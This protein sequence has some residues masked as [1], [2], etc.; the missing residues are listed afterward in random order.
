MKTITQSQSDV[1]AS[2]PH[3]AQVP[4]TTMNF[5][6]T[7]RR[8]G[9]LPPTAASSSDDEGVKNEERLDVDVSV[10]TGTESQEFFHLPSQSQQQQSGGSGE[11]KL[12]DGEMKKAP[13]RDTDRGSVV[14]NPLLFV[15]DRTPSPNISDT[16][17][18]AAAN[19]TSDFNNDTKTSIVTSSHTSTASSAGYSADSPT[20]AVSALP[21]AA[22]ITTTMHRDS[23][24]ETLDEDKL[25]QS[26]QQQDQQQQ[27][28]GQQRRPSSSAT[29]SS[30]VDNTVDS[31]RQCD[32]T[33]SQPPSTSPAA[34]ATAGPLQPI[35]AAGISRAD[36]AGDDVDD[37]EEQAKQR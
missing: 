14:P 37:E 19:A 21:S 30:K 24:N 35:A 29:S 32:D 31:V 12:S 1:E 5:P 2:A 9:T 6:S 18:P 4:T 33:T 7:N 17:P 8:A 15:S 26:L 3:K 34:A 23:S 28:Q 22:D 36:Q 25:L 16:P 27:Q 13:S 10:L 20:V 11:T